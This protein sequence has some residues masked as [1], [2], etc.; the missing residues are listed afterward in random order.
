MNTSLHLA[1]AVA[2]VAGGAPVVG[3]N[4]SIDSSGKD[5]GSAEGASVLTPER[6]PASQPVD[7]STVGAPLGTFQP[8][9]ACITGHA[10]PNVCCHAGPTQPT[11]CTECPAEPFGVCD[12]ESLTFPDPRSCCSL[13]DGGCTAT[14]QSDAGVAGNCLFPCGPGGYPPNELGDAAG[15]PACSDMVDSSFASQ[16][17]YCCV[18][19]V[20]TAGCAAN[21]CTQVGACGPQCGACPTGWQVPPGGID[22]CCRTDSAGV[23]ECFSQANSIGSTFGYFGPGP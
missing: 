6:C 8:V 16:C 20:K 17:A 4:G 19:S 7:V 15:L 1:L 22:L 10:H 18:G 14:T 23:D 9:A 3:C 13:E 12:K 2:L 11:V 5:G 21:T